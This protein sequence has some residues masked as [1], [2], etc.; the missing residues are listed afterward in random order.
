[1]LTIAGTDD[2]GCR[3]GHVCRVV[4]YVLGLVGLSRGVVSWKLLGG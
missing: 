1:M 2:G 3:G 4:V